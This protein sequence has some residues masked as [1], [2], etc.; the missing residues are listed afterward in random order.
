MKT[1]IL[2]HA[3]KD[4]KWIG[5]IYYIQNIAFQLMQND[6][7]INNY[8]IFLYTYEK[9]KHHFSHLDS[10]I[11]IRY[12]KE[13]IESLVLLKH[14]LI[15]RIKYIYPSMK[16][17][18]AFWLKRID[19]IPDFQDSKLSDLFSKDDLEARKKLNKKLS[20]KGRCVVLSSMDSLNDFNT[21]YSPV[22]ANTYVV[23]FVSYI[24]PILRLLKPEEESQI[25]A[26]KD[27]AKRHYACIMNQF[28]QHKNHIVVLKAIKEFIRKNP[29]SDFK[30]VF[31]GK[32]EDYRSPEYIKKLIHL[33][34]EEEIKRHS[35]LLGFVDRVEQIAIMKNSAYIIQPSLS[36]GWGTVVEDAKVLDKTIL[37]SDIPVHREQ[38]NTKC[39][40]FE[41]NDSI[42]LARL[43]EEESER[44]HYDNVEEGIA[45]M[46]RRAK[47]YSKG[48]ET[49]LKDLDISRQGRKTARKNEKG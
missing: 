14:Y 46:Y 5:G 2:L 49:L 42:T 4:E 20:K 25:L 9:N 40:L 15:D 35:V 3:F 41:P 12:F 26:D 23:H 33:F 13:N 21:F 10:K 44:S 17:K 48:F 7:I 1:G 27:L 22:E 30:F 39:R 36:E 32:L 34:E 6:F 16:R 11:R 28:W 29:D 19:W 47:V 43:I 8:T 38:M 45:D 24:E 18:D 31:T 37:L